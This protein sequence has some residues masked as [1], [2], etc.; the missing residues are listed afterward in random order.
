[1]LESRSRSPDRNCIDHNDLHTSGVGTVMQSTISK[2]CGVWPDRERQRERERERER[3]RSRQR[4]SSEPKALKPDTK[5][6]EEILF[7]I[8]H[9]NV[10]YRRDKIEFRILN[11]LR[12]VRVI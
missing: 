12:T 6:L 7:R 9:S 11:T 10:S 8:R 5:R 1:M 2:L 3:E 4:E